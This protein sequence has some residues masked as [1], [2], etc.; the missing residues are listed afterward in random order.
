MLVYTI[1]AISLLR[2]SR[3]ALT[4]G[5]RRSAPASERAALR[6]AINNDYLAAPFPADFWIDSSGRVRRVLVGYRTAHG[7]QIVVDGRFSEFGVKV[8]L[9]VPP[10]RDVQDIT[11]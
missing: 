7:S 5:R 6:A 9:T 1:N 10:A 2:K 3:S 8:D 11:P 4:S